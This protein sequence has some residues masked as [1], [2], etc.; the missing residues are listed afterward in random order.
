LKSVRREWIAEEDSISA[1]SMILNKSTPIMQQEKNEKLI[2]RG[3]E[4]AN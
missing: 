4:L 2:Q 1:G 3:K